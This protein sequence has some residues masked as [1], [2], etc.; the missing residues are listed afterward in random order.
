MDAIMTKK[1]WQH[2]YSEALEMKY[3]VKGERLVTEDKTE[4]SI[5]EARR[6]ESIGGI[7]KTI[8]AVKKVFGGEIVGAVADG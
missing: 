1:A 6:L 4:Y 3:A 2:F 5:Q 7:D 8:H